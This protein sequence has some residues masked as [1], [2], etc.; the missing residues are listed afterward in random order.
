MK[1]VIIYWVIS[2]VIAFF[3]GVE[4][5]G[6]FVGNRAQQILKKLKEDLESK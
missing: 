3:L 2:V 1:A 5:G 4:V 6:R